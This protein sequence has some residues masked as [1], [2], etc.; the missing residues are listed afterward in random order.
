[1]FILWQRV[2]R[3]FFFAIQ[4]ILGKLNENARRERLY[5]NLEKILLT[6]KCMNLQD[7]VTS[8][9]FFHIYSIPCNLQ[10][11]LRSFILTYFSVIFDF[12]L[13]KLLLSITLLLIRI[14]IWGCIPRLIRKKTVIVRA[15]L[16]FRLLSFFSL[17]FYFFGKFV[18]V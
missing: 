6:V 5:F 4:S 13:P 9:I 11:N 2:F 1:M 14:F 8:R 12:N 7:S 10:I 15:W 17:S 18:I 16:S 3:E